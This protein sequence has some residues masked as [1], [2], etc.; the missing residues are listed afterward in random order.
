MKMKM[1]AIVEDN[2]KM[3]TT[4]K[5]ASLDSEAATM[6]KLIFKYASK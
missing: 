1:R 2:P 3:K 6:Y 5:R 4:P